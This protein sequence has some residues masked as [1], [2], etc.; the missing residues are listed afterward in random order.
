MKKITLLFVF[1]FTSQWSIAQPPTVGLLYHDISASDGYTLFTPLKNNEVFL[2]NNCGETVNQWTFTEAPGATC[3]LLANGNLLR[4]GQNNLEIRDWNNNVVWTYA[5]TA[6]GIMQHHDIEPLP[7]GN[8]LCL[9][10]DRYSLAQM[11][12]EGRNPA[13][14]AATMKLEKIV[15]LQPVG[16]NSATIVWEWKFKEHMIQDFDAT[17]LNYGVVADHPE[18]LDLN[19]PNLSTN[20][21]IHTN[22]IDYN[23]A[24][25]QILVSGKNLSEIYIIDHSTT[26]LEASG[27]TGGTSNRGGDFLWRWGNPEVYKQGTVGDRKLFAQHDPKW[28]EPG[29]LDDGKI[30]VFN[31]GVV[32]TMQSYTS[33]VMLQP[34]IVGGIYTKLNNKFN[35]VNYDWSWNGSIL[36]ITVAE[37]KQ[38]GTHALPNGNMIISE[39]TLGRVS[40]ITKSGTV[41]WSYRNPTGPIVGGNS[42]RYA[43]FSDPLSDNSFFRA[44]KYPA[45]YIGFSGHDLTISSGILE[46]VNSLSAACR[47]LGD[48]DFSSQKLFVL[49]PVNHNTIQF[50]KEITADY[51]T[52]FDTNGRKVYSQGS[53]NGDRIE[54][55]LSPAV[56]FMLVQQ[57]SLMTKLK[58]VISK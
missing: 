51:V 18:L 16:T 43:Q 10:A 34:E 4:A 48:N 9:A 25:D 2:V 23:A 30:T 11:T 55:N 31:N 28:V 46:D 49:N 14:T 41:V 57:G 20:D 24:L 33:V 44:E 17:K 7:N 47:E 13:T 12:A 50:N 19:Y 29:Y 52:V 45:N 22:G 32:G 42:I 39:T 3:Y 36:G 21:Y 15:E 40:E 53:F 37:D 38:S 8:I 56:Y 27:H 1:I 5:T 6:N 58:I 54:V 35:P 26:T